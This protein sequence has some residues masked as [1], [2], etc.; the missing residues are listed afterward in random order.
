MCDQT[1]VT[2]MLNGE[3]LEA[4]PLRQDIPYFFQYSAW[5]PSCVSKPRD[6]IK[7]DKLRNEHL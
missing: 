3:K 1:I 5:S 7:S 6:G 4:F 2:L